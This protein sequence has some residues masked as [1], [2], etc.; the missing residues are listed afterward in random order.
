MFQNRLFEADKKNTILYSL[1]CI[2]L[3]IAIGIVSR[4]KHNLIDLIECIFLLKLGVSGI[5]A[6]VMESECGL[7]YQ[8]I[9]SMLF[10]MICMI[11][12]FIILSTLFI[13]YMNGDNHWRHWHREMFSLLINAFGPLFIVLTALTVNRLRCLVQAREASKLL[14]VRYF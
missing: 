12:E 1:S 8:L 10:F 5:L 6:A 13:M 4:H 3:A 14:E 11:H 7:I 2:V 9:A